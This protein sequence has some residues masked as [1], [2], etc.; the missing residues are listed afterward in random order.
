MI[1]LSQQRCILYKV[2]S[3]QS[4]GIGINPPSACSH[5][6]SP[7]TNTSYSY[8]TC[9]FKF[10]RISGEPVV[11]NIYKFS[12]NRPVLSCLFLSSLNGHNISGCRPTLPPPPPPLS[13]GSLLC[14]SSRS[15]PSPAS[16]LL[17]TYLNMGRLGLG[18]GL[19]RIY[20]KPPMKVRD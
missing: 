9:V 17:L 15:Y 5:W 10:P 16:S 12:I 20:D 2:I 7:S 8:E 14:L 6:G 13:D 11:H 3:F 1:F 18:T 19:V 4:L